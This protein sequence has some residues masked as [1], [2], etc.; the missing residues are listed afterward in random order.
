MQLPSIYLA[1]QSPRRRE[2]LR[3]IGVAHEVIPASVP[4]Q[5]APGEAAVDYA[6]R[7]AQQKAAAGY[8]AVVA[9]GLPLAPVLGADTLGLFEGEILEKPRDRDHGLAMLRRLSGRSHQ[10]ITAVALQDAQRQALRVSIT[11]V[12]FR[13]LDEAEIIAYWE[14]GEPCDKAGSYA[15]QGLGAVFVQSIQGSYSGV[16]GLPL[17]ATVDLLREFAIPWWQPREPAAEFGL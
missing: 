8:A 16:V 5:P 10:V 13:P 15:I 6:Q 9:A 14:T 3:Q 17:E 7:L 12:K 4:E 1:S 2:L 11:Q